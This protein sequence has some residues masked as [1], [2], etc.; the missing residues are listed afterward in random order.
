MI[1]TLMLAFALTGLLQQSAT[2]ADEDRPA[3]YLKR[4]QAPPTY[5][6]NKADESKWPSMIR[7]GIDAGRDYFGNYGPVY[8]YI[9]GHKDKSLNS[10]SFHNELVEAYCR[11]R[12]L[13]DSK[14]QENCVDRFSRELINK[15]RSGRGDA[16]LSYVNEA[17]TAFAELVFINPHEFRDP[18]LHTRG[19]HEYTHVFQR[20]YPKTPTWMTEGCAEFFAS[21]LGEKHGWAG[22]RSDMREYLRNVRRI[23]DPKLGIVDMEDVDKVTPEVKKYYR[24]LAYDSGAWAVAFI[25]LESES[26]K[27]SAIRSQLYPLV[28]SKGWEAAMV[29]FSKSD[30]KRDFYE[31][32]ERYMNRTEAELLESLE[33][34]KE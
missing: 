31:R 28:A 23:E 30:S 32:F 8:V 2:P 7:N 20:A 1:R 12:K 5:T 10:D 22:F 34:I 26:R 27:A 21:Y 14:S 16:Y 17:D 4:Q 15:A 24:H 29:E 18:Y 9:L 25:I 13:R 11:R 33:Q 6:R 19:I 3:R